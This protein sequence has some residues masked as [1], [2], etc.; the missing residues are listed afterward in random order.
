[1]PLRRYR[2]SHLIRP[3]FV[4]ID[5]LIIIGV[6]F[7]IS[8]TEF[9]NPFFLTYIVVFWLVIAF[10]TNFY[11]VYRF[12]KTY[13]LFKL[14]L[15]QFALFF[16]GYFTYFG[17]FK[18]G[19]IVNNQLL[20]LSAIIIA[21][22]VFKFISFYLLKRYRLGGKNYRSV[23]VIGF[24]GTSKKIIELFKKRSDLGYRYLGFF[25]NKISEDN[26]YLGKLNDSFNYILKHNIDEIY[27]TLSVLKSKQVKEFTKF[28]NNHSKIIKLIPDS[29]ELYSKSIGAEYYSDILVL[30]VKKLPFEILDNHYIKRSFDILFSLFVIIFIMSW[31][32][33]IFWIIIKLESKGPL[34]FKQEREGLNGNK[35][36]C[37]KFR[38]MKANKD[39]DKLHATKYDERVTWF[40]SFLRKSSMDELPQ[41]FNVLKGEMSVVGPRPH[42]K[43]LS[44]E[45]QKEIDNYMERH[46]VKPGITGLA[47]VSGY[48]GEVKESSDI[49]NRIRLDIF[50]IENW[51]FL[52]D[53]KIIL[54]T[55]FNVFKGEEKA[56]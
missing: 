6:V 46:A 40:G 2:Y 53:F 19:I 48:R 35:F 24:D 11:K 31:L 36:T 44:I 43:S 50:Y 55:V 7:F 51:S 26:E 15:I 52:L 30:N 25:S 49:K 33:P 12:T 56:Y 42:M 32:T 4:L 29:N 23:V 18:E 47:Q 38:S 17:V 16:L 8:D 54:Q 21:I 22:S 27:C 45:Y 10:N 34:F 20:V 37:Y 14:L 13:R 5:I 41:F 1:M 9:Y 28:A 39:S 3:L